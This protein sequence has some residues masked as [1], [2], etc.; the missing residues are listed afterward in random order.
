MTLIHRVGYAILLVV[1][2]A[3]GWAWKT[4]QS[5]A[6]LKHVP[7]ELAYG[8]TRFRLA[9]D[10]WHACSIHEIR[11]LH[12]KYGSAVRVGPNQISFNSLSALRTIYG[13]GSGFERT[14]FYRIFD[15]YGRPN[16]FTF[17]SGVDH[18]NRKKLISHMYSNQRLMEEQCVNM[19]KGKVQGFLDMLRREPEQASEIF[20]SLHYFSFDAISEFVYGSRYG[21]TTA[22]GGNK[23]DR[24]L[25]DDILDPA[26]RR[27]AWFAI[28]F[29]AYTAW[30][31]TRTGILGRVIE[32]LGLLPMKRPFTYS[33]IR[34]HALQACLSYKTAVEAEEL[35]LDDSTV[36]G[37]LFQVREKYQ[38]SDMDIA[39]ECA[40]HLLAGIDTTAD[41]LMFLI[42]A[43][44]LP[45]HLRYQERL[46]KELC[47][48]TVDN[49][50]WPDVKQLSRLPW[51]NAILKE[52]LR[53]YTPLPAFEPREA[54]TAAIIDGVTVPARTVVGMSPYCMHR[55][56]SVFP[57][58][59]V[60][61]PERW[62]QE[63]GSLLPES[64]AQNKWFWAF[65]S[66]A[67]M[68]IGMHLANAEMLMLVAVLYRR[69]TT[70]ARH[71]D[72]SPGITSR[73]EVFSDESLSKIK[74]HECWINFRDIRD[75]KMFMQA[76]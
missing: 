50:G 5:Y 58:P 59:K 72:T 73:F 69:Y 52:S 29:P 30:I 8:L 14:S 15:A 62:L 63:D 9:Y 46:R 47:A 40:D 48:I 27:L 24:R 37:R 66:G 43:L 35:H 4:V 26:R 74:E 16:L 31:T 75:R 67:R 11:A 7:G 45:Q 20:A 42:W 23:V 70:S 21:G 10:A 68:C 61:K 22:L 1:V 3:L 32:S 76:R 18:R 64:A 38:L 41:S 53:L 13:A 17:A 36:I 55:E 44:S 25:I 28:H 56:E 65:S 54:P 71:P 6:R 57:E 49:A 39:S 12:Q 60:F 19:V 2:L 33:G 34:G 51:L